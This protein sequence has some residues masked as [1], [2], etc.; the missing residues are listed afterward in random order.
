MLDRETSRGGSAESDQEDIDIA[1]KGLFGQE[2][3]INLLTPVLE[4][5]RLAPAA[6][7]GHLVRNAWDG[8]PGVVGYRWSR[9]G[10]KRE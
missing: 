3:A 2:V 10:T 5:D 9:I 1:L 4:E 7:L 8:D 6:P